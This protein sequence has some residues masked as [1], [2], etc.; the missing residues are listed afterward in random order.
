MAQLKDTTVN[1]TLT[2]N[3]VD[4]GEKM[5][6]VDELNNKLKNIFDYEQ[7]EATIEPG[8]NYSSV[9]GAVY[10]AGTTL[11]LSISAT[12]KSAPTVGDIANETV[13]TVTF[14]HNGKLT[15]LYNNT[16]TTNT[17]GGVNSLYTT[18][19]V[20]EETTGTLAVKLSAVTTT[21]TSITTYIVLPI[22]LN[23]DAF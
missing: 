18:G 3:G 4:V 17:K 8:D 15:G 5:D 23:L 13:G 21:S 2:V 19:S 7:L 6:L 20:I 16:G 11:R 1:G 9:T 10:R 22:S 14:V 12:R